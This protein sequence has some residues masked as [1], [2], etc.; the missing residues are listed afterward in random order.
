MR[1]G[2]SADLPAGS[3]LPAALQT[4]EF[5]N[6][7]FEYLQR[8]RSRY[9]SRFT[10]HVLDKPPL[11]F[12][13]DPGEVKQLFAGS[14]EVLHPGEGGSAIRPI[15]GDRSFMM[16]DEDEHLAG[17]RTVMPAFHQSA[18]LRHA[19]MVAELAAREVSAWPRNA[20][21]PLH[22]RLRA[23]TLEVVLRTIFGS[24]RD[25]QLRLL[26]GRLLTA[27]EVAGTTLLSLPTLRQFPGGRQKW[28]RFLRRREEADELLYALI[29][30]RRAAL[31]EHDDVLEMICAANAADESPAGRR[32]IRDDV[33]SVI[34]AGHETTASALAWAFQLLAH[35]PGTLERLVAE[36]DDGDGDAYLKATA[37][38]VLRNR[39]VFLFTIP[40]AV[41][42]PVQ[43]GGRA[44]SPPAYL[45]GS[46]Y[47][48]HHDPA[49]YPDPHV[50]RP[51]RF[52]ERAP[53]APLWLP[54]GGGRKRCP[55]LHL[56]LLEMETVMRAVLGAVSLRPAGARIERPAWRNVIVT[57]AAGCRVSLDAR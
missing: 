6:R 8:C 45:L 3:R 18:V 31:G 4:W 9:G 1:R 50:F 53:T 56:A 25:R 24:D 37:Q 52:L 14:A 2:G 47:L 39:P 22:P 38:E 29:D 55:G 36:L 42:G 46:I 7:P 51:E 26:H 19:D 54:W 33:M 44:Y 43:V 57:P 12:L 15:V 48:I 17:R 21:I 30:E 27:L 23:L 11:V 10:A 40:R 16:L 13:A 20:P 32:S 28:S 41:K 49:L 34:L 5:A 35:N